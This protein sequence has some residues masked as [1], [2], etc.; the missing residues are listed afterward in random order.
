MA[1][2]CRHDRE[3]SRHAGIHSGHYQ[4]VSCIRV[5]KVI[6]CEVTIAASYPIERWIDRVEVIVVQITVYVHGAVAPEPVFT[7][8]RD[9]DLQSLIVVVRCATLLPGVDL[10]RC[11]ER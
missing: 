3:C 11:V 5:E 9:V 8:E 6:H 7:T 10:T 4:D 2:A 1:D